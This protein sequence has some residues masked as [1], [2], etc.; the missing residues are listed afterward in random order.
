M[1]N[2]I[3]VPI[4]IEVPYGQ[5]GFISFYIN[6]I[7]YDNI[8]DFTIK[9]YNNEIY[10]FEGTVY[11]ANKDDTNIDIDID[12]MIFAGNTLLFVAK[13]DK[14]Q[15]KTYDEVFISGIC[16]VA[17]AL[18][19]KRCL[20]NVENKSYFEEKTVSYIIQH[21]CSVNDDGSSPWIASPT[22]TG[23]TETLFVRGDNDTKLNA[24][25]NTLTVSNYEWKPNYGTA[26]NETNILVQPTNGSSVS[27][28]TI[29]LSGEN[30]NA[31]LS[32]REED[33]D[34]L[35]NDVLVA[36]YGDGVNQLKSR[37]LS[38]SVNK[39]YLSSAITASATT[40]TVDNG[41]ILDSTGSVVIGCEIIPYTRSGNT[42]T[43][44]RSSAT[45]LEGTNIVD[46][47][48]HNAGIAVYD[49]FTTSSPE[50]NS[51]VD[52][53]GHQQSP[54]QTN[55][56]IIDQNMLDFVA[57]NLLSEH[58]TVVVKIEAI[59][60]DMFDTLETIELGD[61]ITI[62]DSATGNNDDYRVIGLEINDY[63]LKL[64]LSN[65][66]KTITGSIAEEESQEKNL[67]CYMQGTSN[68]VSIQS[69]ENAQQTS[70]PEDGAMQMKFRIWDKTI[71]IK[72]ARLDMK[73]V[74][75]RGYTTGDS[76]S[77]TVG[78]M[79]YS[80]GIFKGGSIPFLVQGVPRGSGTLYNQTGGLL[81]KT[82]DGTGHVTSH[83]ASQSYPACSSDW[84]YATYSYSTPHYIFTTVP[85]VDSGTFS[86]TIVLA[87]FSNEYNGSRNF[88]WELR[89]DSTSGTIL[90]SG[91]KTLS[92]FAHDTFEI[93][94]TSSDYI[95]HG[96]YLVL[97]SPNFNSTTE[98]DESHIQIL[99]Y[100]Y[101]STSH[102][103][104]STYGITYDS[105]TPDVKVAIGDDDDW[106]GTKTYINS[107]SA[108][109][110]GTN[111]DIDITSALKNIVGDLSTT[112]RIRLQFEPQGSG[113]T[114]RIEANVDIF[115]FLGSV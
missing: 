43:L 64:I 32:T 78:G 7:L 74:P 106:A 6:G 54:T 80:Q 30:Q 101:P 77:T 70:T 98:V 61:T 44:T 48:S 113:N 11:G 5:K 20:N 55:T 100:T 59:M 35:W 99:I 89:L 83:Y 46:S 92:A 13:L 58:D 12:V 4:H 65:A 107:G 91:T 73:I 68:L 110:Y 103:H 86:K 63:E 67:N 79:G 40:A 115:T 2:R 1:G 33:T 27:V 15:W 31:E 36:G 28:M 17:S 114:C 22:I 8:S 90:A 108:Y 93:L 88:V 50:T 87:H 102:T 19:K 84:S 69:Y 52:L 25:L 109:S 26:Y 38:T 57:Q 24:I 96:L 10:T 45:F 66:S 21:L 47:Y 51:S 94:D 18:K 104:P 105:D 29:S 76:G 75:F 71:A 34:E 85:N 60:A 39:T 49:Y 112:K 37:C 42:L 23:G 9:M 111:N 3:V 97:T 82:I 72:D 53:N 41:D 56:S 95:G 62:S 16:K 14:P 81:P